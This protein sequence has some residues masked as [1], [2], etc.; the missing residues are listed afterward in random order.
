MVDEE[1]E[2]EEKKQSKKRLMR[3]SEIE[4][5]F[6]APVTPKKI[7]SMMN[8][9]MSSSANMNPLMGSAGSFVS[10][11]PD[12]DMMS[13]QLSPSTLNRFDTMNVSG[14]PNASKMNAGRGTKNKQNMKP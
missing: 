8:A 5:K 11:Q 4:A 6:K 3:T 7:V 2:E 1:A 13:T 10:G 14:S 9:S 12:F